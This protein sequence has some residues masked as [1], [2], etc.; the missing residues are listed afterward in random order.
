M[1]RGLSTVTVRD[2]PSLLEQ[3]SVYPI[4]SPFCMSS[5]GGSQDNVRTVLSATASMKFSGAPLGARNI[6]NE[7]LKYVIDLFKEDY[8]LPGL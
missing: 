8:L 6:H 5:A 1:F 2:A 3:L 4:M 7:G